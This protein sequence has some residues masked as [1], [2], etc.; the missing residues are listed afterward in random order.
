VVEVFKGA[1]EELGGPICQQN[2]KVS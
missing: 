1:G 2:I